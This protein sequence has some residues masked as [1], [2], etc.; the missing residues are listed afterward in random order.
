MLPDDASKANFESQLI[1]NLVSQL[2][3]SASLFSI[4]SVTSGSI[5]V[6][7]QVGRNVAVQM[8][9]GLVT[10]GQ[11][12]FVFGGKIV[13][14]DPLSFV[15][16]ASVSTSSTQASTVASAAASSAGPI[17]AGALLGIIIGGGCGIIILVI[18]ISIL[19]RS[20]RKNTRRQASL[21]V[22]ADTHEKPTQQLDAAHALSESS[23]VD[24]VGDHVF[25]NV[26]SSRN[27]ELDFTSITRVHT[28]Q[29][30]KVNSWRVNP[31]VEQ[32]M[33]TQKSFYDVS[34]DE[35]TI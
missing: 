17:S 28:N 22:I 13:S 30:R 10:S 11:F 35:E 27:E 1:A 26:V 23:T 20:A 4:V 7:V 33:P 8:V 2:H 19:I 24:E 34:F 16:H 6:T 15:N 31:E 9:Q 29:M 14:A 12:S 3:L 32:K 21:A 18:V 25:D 5:I